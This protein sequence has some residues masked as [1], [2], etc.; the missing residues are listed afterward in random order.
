MLYESY[1]ALTVVSENNNIRVW[2]FIYVTIWKQGAGAESL[3]RWG[4]KEIVLFM[5]NWLFRLS[6]VNTVSI[7]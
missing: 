6:A 5:A 4:C 1:H 2:Q 3:T 7:N